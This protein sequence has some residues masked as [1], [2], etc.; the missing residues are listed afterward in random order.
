[1]SMQQTGRPSRYAV[2]RQVRY[3]PR[4]GGGELDLRTSV[5]YRIWDR[6]FGVFLPGGFATAADAAA[7]VPGPADGAPAGRVPDRPVAGR[8]RGLPAPIPGR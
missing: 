3:L 6:A 4:P 7:H 5:V 1:M 8:G 2:E